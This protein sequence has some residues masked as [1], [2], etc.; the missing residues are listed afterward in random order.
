MPLTWTWFCSPLTP[1]WFRAVWKLSDLLRRAIFR[2][3]NSVKHMATDA[4]AVFVYWPLARLCRVGE[5]LGFNTASLPLYA[6]RAASFYT[7]RTDARDRF[8]TPLERRFSR[9]QIAGMM[10]AA[11]LIDVQFSDAAPYWCAVGIRGSR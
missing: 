2:L 5:L 7:M 10:A 4:L 8:G 3:P 1:W 9:D 11:G 6:Y